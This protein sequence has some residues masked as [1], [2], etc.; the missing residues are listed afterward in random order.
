[1]QPTKEL[2]DQLFREKVEWAKQTPPAERFL[3]GARL[4]DRRCKIMLAGL[5]HRHPEAS[6]AE[7]ND[8]L[9]GQIELLRKL[10]SRP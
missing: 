8:M 5:R 10:E 6:E 7:L 4:F 1:M 2:A 9:H 3:D